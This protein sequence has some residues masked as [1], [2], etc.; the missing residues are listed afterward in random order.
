MK[1]ILPLVFAL[2][3][4]VGIM[5]A[6]DAY[7]YGT[8]GTTIKGQGTGASG[9]NYSSAI[10]VPASVAAQMKGSKVTKVQ[11]GFDSGVAK[12]VTVFITKDLYGERL[13]TQKTNVKAA[14]YNEVV[15]TEPYEIDGEEFYIG[16]DYRQSTSAGSPIGFDNNV[17]G[18]NSC[19]DLMAV[20]KDGE[21]P[22]YEHYGSLFGNLAL[23]AEIEGVNLPKYAIMPTGIETPIH[24][25][26]GDEFKYS[27]TITNVGT[28]NVSE[29][30]ILHNIGGEKSE[31]VE[32]LVPALKPG[33]SKTFEF[34]GSSS[35]EM[36]EL[37]ISVSVTKVGTEENCWGFLEITGTLSNSNKVSPRVVVIEEYTGVDCGYCPMG[38]IALENMR[39]RHP[40]TYIGIAVHNYNMTDPMKCA[41]Y[42]SW[43]ARW[44]T[45]APQATAN[46]VG[47]IGAFQPN[48][49][50]CEIVYNELHTMIPISMKLWAWYPNPN[51]KTKITTRCAT[52]IEGD[53]D[54]LNYGLAW[55]ITEDN[56]GPY[57]QANYF[58]GGSLGAMEGFEEK[59][60]PVSLM[61]NDVARNVFHWNGLLGSIPSKM[62]AGQAHYTDF[63]MPFDAS[64]N[65]NNANI[66]ALLINRSTGEIITAAKC[67]IG[68]NEP[69]GINMVVSDKIVAA[70]IIAVTG[71]VKVEGDVAGVEVYSLSG[72]KVAYS[73]EAG[74]IELPAGIYVVKATDTNNNTTTAKVAVK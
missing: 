57:N 9:T 25:L 69:S 60:N 36:L 35:L 14:R 7:T 65:P 67:K 51:D 49:S 56:V 24:S 58:S 18:A 23:K 16:Y 27:M 52:T 72:V 73:N 32:K 53:S 10:K 59:S 40:D 5:S 63:D 6:Q 74:A 13:C 33:D 12:V 43:A 66:I 31:S 70:E 45:G 47:S 61:F 4:C 42:S 41:A 64:V 8:P 19:F 26:V 34:T 22:K 20:Y 62:Y 2:L 39:E 44:I 29:V 17:A 37:P 50:N 48:T 1:R 54:N 11:V 55:V 38:W 15:L 28:Q 68:E 46:R 21:T 3:A 71:G 30:T